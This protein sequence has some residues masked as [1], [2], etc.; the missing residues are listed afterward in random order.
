[1]DLMIQ[2]GLVGLL[3]VLLLAGFLW[4]AVRLLSRATDPLAQWQQ[5]ADPSAAGP[6]PVPVPVVSER[7]VPTQP[8][9]QPEVAAVDVAPISEP[10][11]PPAGCLPCPDGAQVLLSVQEVSR[12][13]TSSSGEK[14]NVLSSV[15]VE[16]REGDMV[17]I[18]GSS[19][20][21]KTTL[22]HLLAGLDT[23]DSGRIFWLGR[24]LPSREGKA[25]RDYR[26]EK[27]SLVFQSLNLV[28]HLTAEENAALPL[29][30]RGVPWDEVVAV[31]RE[32]L[33]LLGLE[34]KF[35]QRPAHLS[36]GEQQRVAVAR[37]FTSRAEL[38][39]AD[40]P[41]GSLDPATAAGVMEAFHQLSRRWR[42]TVV[43]VTHNVNLARRYSD[44]L[45]L[46]TPQGLVDI[47]RRSK[48]RLAPLSPGRSSRPNN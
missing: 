27:V 7:L 24:P 11:A 20:A 30:C 44:R 12:S 9:Q 31:A 29:L 38:I 47:T 33:R 41:T 32:N 1:M 34:Q 4:V 35:R 13:F 10:V 21:G 26:A 42:K 18:V 15:S 22:L 36:G 8:A 28:T 17:A 14:V 45:L 25:L 2:L 39:L 16:I 43:L 48:G 23:P 3:M 40:E 19:G 5:L 46:C 37:A 6:W